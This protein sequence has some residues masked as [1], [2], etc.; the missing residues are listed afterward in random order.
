MTELVSSVL[1]LV[2]Q[3]GSVPI[4]RTDAIHEPP[5]LRCQRL[6]AGPT[7][8]VEEFVEPALVGRPLLDLLLEL[9]APPG[10]KPALDWSDSSRLG[11]GCVLLRAEA[12]VS[13]GEVVAERPFLHDPMFQNAELLVTG[14]HHEHAE[15]EDDHFA[16][17]DGQKDEE[18][19]RHETGVAG[20]L[21]GRAVVAGPAP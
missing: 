18:Q 6:L 13:L 9:A 20:H 1:C 2:S 12:A 14:H 15:R 8:L 3:S 11:R 16:S 4:P 19:R 21:R 7:D 17:P 5:L 10:L